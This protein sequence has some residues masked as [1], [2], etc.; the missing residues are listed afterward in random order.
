K[1]EEHGL[2]LVEVSP[3][4][5]PPVARLL[6]YGAFKYQKEKEIRKQRAQSKEVEIK[7]IRLSVRISEHDMQIRIE[8]AK[9][10]L[11]RGDKVK[12][13]IILRGR[14]KAY[15]ELAIETVQRFV[16]QLGATFS[17]RVEQ[18]IKRQGSSITAIITKT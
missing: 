15:P 8:Q 12:P 16:N 5:N 4:A 3:K 11:E 14:E 18:E 9:K 1:A 13:E 17:L 7:G 2:D 10:F 6:E